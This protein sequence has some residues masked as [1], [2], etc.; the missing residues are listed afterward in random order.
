MDYGSDPFIE[1]E[2][3]KLRIKVSSTQFDDRLTS[4]IRTSCGVIEHY[5]G[6]RIKANN[7]S[8]SNFIDNNNI[9]VRAK[10]LN[11]VNNIKVGSVVLYDPDSNGQRKT[12]T[13]IPF[14]SNNTEIDNRSG[15]FNNSSI[16]FTTSTGSISLSNVPNRMK[17]LTSGFTTEFWFKSDTDGLPSVSEIF[18]I[19]TDDSNKFTIGFS[20]SEV[21]VQILQ[22]QR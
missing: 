11:R 17:P 1:L 12:G 20:S 2:E 10:P 18:S 8:I 19:S 22:Q 3:T 6:Q 15:K 14:E 5:I 16:R 7:Y 4:M 21:L 9:H 13:P